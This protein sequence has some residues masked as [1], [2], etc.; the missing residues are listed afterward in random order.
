[1]TVTNETLKEY[2]VKLHGLY[3]SCFNILTAMN[4]SLQTNASEITVDMVD[5]NGTETTLRIPSFMYLEN[6]LEQLDNNFG[7]LFKMP[8]SGD[9]WF[10]KSSNMYKLQLVR[11]S[12]APLTP[13]FNL[14]DVYAGSTANNILKDLV[15]PKTYLRLNITN[16][17]ENTDQMFMRKIVIFDKVTYDALTNLNLI[18]Y[19]DY[20][21]A[22]YNYNKGEDYEEYDSTIKLPIKR[23][24]Y[25][26]QFNIIEIPD[27]YDEYS[28]NPWVDTTDG[29]HSHLTY[30]LVL[31]TLEYTDQEDSSIRFTIKVGD[32]L[33]LG[34]EMVV[35][36]VKNVDTTSN[37]VIIEEQ[38]GHIALQTFEENSQMVLS[39]YNDR[40]NLGYVDVPLE[41]NQYIV[42][43][44][45]VIYNNVRS[46]LSNAYQVDLSTIYM[47]DEQGNPILD[48]FGN[49]MTYMDYYNTYCTNIGD[50]ILGLTQSAYPQ[51]SNYN[52]GQL[53]S[54][55]NGEDIQ[56]AVSN[57]LDPEEILQV[58]PINKHLTDDVSSEEIIN[59]H[60]QKNDVQAQLATIQDNISQ[61]YNT[62][63]NT[64]FS[65]QTSNTMSALQ[66]KLQ[67]YYTERTTLQKQ[68]FLLPKPRHIKTAIFIFMTLIFIR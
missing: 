16:L 26:S 23:D 41:E 19:E 63:T 38:V 60:A 6:R 68:L 3:E 7:N 59:L 65:Q 43:F 49:P 13:L 27:S 31:D 46:I 18:T 2:Y 20:A 25:K 34:N 51:I 57:T 50:L 24:V 22:L 53:N 4:Q 64:D 35:Y 61:V 44:L 10:T 42:V 29:Q 8:D 37:T 17:P 52:G 33:C 5:A 39:I 15:S 47:R 28:T 21:A 1:M 55:Q 11:S 56:K 45:G 48:S 40:Y 62:L 67:R 14:D 30:R 32:Y 9:A 58:V 54:L 12:S 66:S 36:L